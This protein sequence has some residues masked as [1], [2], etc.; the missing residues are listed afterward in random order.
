M[1][2][3]AGCNVPTTS[4]WN[5]SGQNKKEEKKKREEEEEEEGK[6]P[7]PLHPPSD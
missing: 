3:L 7:P 5:F 4:S 2:G 1:A 6:I